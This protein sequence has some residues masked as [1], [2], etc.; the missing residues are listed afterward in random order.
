[1]DPVTDRTQICFCDHMWTY[2]CTILHD[3]IVSIISGVGRSNTQ[4]WKYRA[5]VVRLKLQNSY[6]R[7][8]VKY[9]G[10]GVFRFELGCGYYFTLR[11]EDGSGSCKICLYVFD[12][13]NIE[14]NMIIRQKYQIQKV[15]LIQRSKFMID[16]NYQWI[17]KCVKI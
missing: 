6:T 3:Q 5:G 7:M 8:H 16:S 9:D 4:R 11:F 1:M 12:M 17:K 13:H 2:I 10:F 14:I 15:S